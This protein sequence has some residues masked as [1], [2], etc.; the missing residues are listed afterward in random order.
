MNMPIQNRKYFIAKHN[1]D[2]ED[3]NNK[4]SNTN[5]S[6]LSGDATSTFTKM[7]MSDYNRMK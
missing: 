5:S 7:S 6:T 2:C 1:K 3:I 4:H